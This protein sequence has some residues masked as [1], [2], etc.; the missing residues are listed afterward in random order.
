MHRPRLIRGLR[1][2]WSVVWGLLCVLLI[3]LW[4]RSYWRMDIVAIPSPSER[5]MA[6]SYYGRIYWSTVALDKAVSEPDAV[7]SLTFM[8]IGLW[9]KR[10]STTCSM[11]VVSIVPAM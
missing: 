3:V 5:F 9:Y 4:V 8:T 6:V 10:L 2:A 7:G 11:T 1:I